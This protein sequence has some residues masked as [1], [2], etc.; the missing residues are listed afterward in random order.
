MLALL[1]RRDQYHPRAKSLAPAVRSASEVW[2]T[3][4]VLLEIGNALARSNRIEAIRFIDSCYT[5]ANIRVVS[6]APELF[7]RGVELYRDRTDKGWSLTDCTS[8]VVM[9]DQGLT[10]ALTA[11]DHFRQAGF[12]ALLRE[13]LPV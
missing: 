13:D 4:V 12:R 5:T 7:R 1:N 9:Q 6:L 11:D 2:V 3:E 10:H 8:F